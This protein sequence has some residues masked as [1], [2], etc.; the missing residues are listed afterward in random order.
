MTSLAIRNALSQP[1]RA[2]D[3]FNAAQLI[4]PQMTAKKRQSAQLSAG[5]KDENQGAI[6]KD[7]KKCRKV[8]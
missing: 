7:L 8:P 6:P 1:N 3:G 4:K 2:L 5:I